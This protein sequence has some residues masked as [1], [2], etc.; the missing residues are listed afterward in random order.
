MEFKEGQRIGKWTLLM[1]TRKGPYR[2][3]ECKCDCGTL[4]VVPEFTFKGE[5]S[6]RCRQ[7]YL[8]GPRVPHA[9]LHEV[10]HRFGKLVIVSRFKNGQKS[11]YSMQCDCGTSVAM[12]VGMI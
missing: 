12:Q 2:A 7:C 9:Y 4:K 8:K 5:K 3:W 10:G 11:M 1:P 6:D